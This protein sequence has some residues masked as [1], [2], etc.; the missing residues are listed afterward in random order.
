[1]AANP[2]RPKMADWVTLGMVLAA[3]GA[4]IAI[5]TVFHGVSLM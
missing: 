3:G 5:E 4:A 2:Q 1:L